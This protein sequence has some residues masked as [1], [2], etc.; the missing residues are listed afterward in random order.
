MLH[1]LIVLSAADRW[2]RADGSIYESGVWAEEFV[3]MDEAFINAGFS[4][5]IASP[6]GIAPTMDRRS[7]DPATVGE[8]TAKRMRTILPRTSRVLRS[9]WS[10]PMSTSAAIRL[11]LFLEAMVR[12]RISTRILTWDVFWSTLIGKEG[13]SRRFV[14]V[15][16]HCWR[17]R[18]R[19][20]GGSS[21]AA[22]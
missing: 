14:M 12:S 16:Q 2:T 13:S 22:G 10:S 20:A 4:V 9:R 17:R 11:W 5:D 19:M 8:E 21:P 18:T 3:V 15:L 6:G 1:I 7:L